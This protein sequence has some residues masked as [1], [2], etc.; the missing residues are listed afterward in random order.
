MEKTSISK[1]QT[2]AE[3]I[4]SS[5]H[6]V[7]F[8][9]AGISTGSGLPDYRGPD[10]VW[11][12]RDKG[13]EPKPLSKPWAEFEPNPAHYAIVDLQNLGYLKFLISQNVDNLH[14]KSG[15]NPDLIAEL[16]GNSTKLKCIQCDSRYVKSDLGW[17]VD[18]FG[19]GYR[20]STP[21]P[22]QPMCPNCSGRL[23]SEIVNF[24]DPMPDRETTLSYDHAKNSDVFFVIGSS[25]VV[26][27]AASYPRIAKL[28]GAKLII[29]NKG[30]TPLDV[31]ADIK[32]DEDIMEIIP[33]IVEIVKMTN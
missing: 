1:I 16:H 6:L 15:I 12:R 2:I 9:G 11:T 26:N 23:I 27:P 18:A 33:K 3:W 29:V 5:N 32:L 21:H 24:G 4:K 19:R 25:L 17:N 28:N 30:M 14:I 8:T 20:K 31:K 10:G 7:V 13:L 22:D